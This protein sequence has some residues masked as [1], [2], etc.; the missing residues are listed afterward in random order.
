MQYNLCKCINNKLITQLIPD[1]GGVLLRNLAVFY[2][3]IWRITL[4]Q[5]AVAGINTIF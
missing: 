1:F 2:S 4:T 3:G 5:I